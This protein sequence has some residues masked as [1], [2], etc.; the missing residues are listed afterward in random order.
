ML[1][2]DL[3]RQELAKAGGG[4][5]GRLDLFGQ[6]RSEGVGD[7]AS[8][9]Q[10]GRHHRRLAKLLGKLTD[11]VVIGLFILAPIEVP[12]HQRIA[13][14]RAGVV[15][16]GGPG[17]P[18]AIGG[19][20]HGEQQPTAGDLPQAHGLIMTA[21]EQSATIGR[22]GDRPDIAGM[23]DE[24]VALLAAGAVVAGENAVTATT[25]DG[26]PIGGE[27]EAAVVITIGSATGDAVGG[28][29]ALLDQQG[30][31]HCAIGGGDSGCPHA[32]NRP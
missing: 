22:G 28:G 10:I 32:L 16:F 15:A 13:M 20:E 27:G 29:A 18:F 8:V 24:V 2:E 1:D 31:V 4:R 3:R 21:R 17:D 23:A 9:T 7:V 12:T 14:Q 5:A 30:R 26:G 25:D 11:G 6:G 19:G